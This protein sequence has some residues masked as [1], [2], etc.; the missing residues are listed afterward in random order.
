[1][2]SLYENMRYKAV[3]VSPVSGRTPTLETKQTRMLIR[4]QSEQV[5]WVS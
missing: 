3:T 1:M 2:S 4:M 5:E